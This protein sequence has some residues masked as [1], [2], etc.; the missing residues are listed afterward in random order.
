MKILVI[1]PNTSETNRQV[2]VDVLTPY[3]EPNLE[4]DVVNAPKGPEGII[5]WVHKQI[6]GTEILP[7]ITKA[8]DDGYNGVVIACFGD[9]GIEAAKELSKIPVIGIAEAA[10]LL[11]PML[12]RKFLLLETSKSSIPRMEQ[13]IRQLGLNKDLIEFRALD[14]ESDWTI[15]DSLANPEKTKQL[16]IK[17]CRK[18]MDESS[19]D[20]IIPGCSAI[21]EHTKAI[22]E[23][24]GVPV[25]DPVVTAVQI[26]IALIKMNLAQSKRFS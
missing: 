5:S 9:T 8:E 20:L 15:I 17:T 13:F 23:E 22:Q 14:S 1:N 16:I 18:I 25:I 12:S 19:V 21:S 11:A 3:H 6:Q 2:I 26:I 24:L 10:L 4:I 7:M